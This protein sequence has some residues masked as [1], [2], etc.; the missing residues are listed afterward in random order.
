MECA[1][2]NPAEHVEACGVLVGILLRGVDHQPAV[3]VASNHVLVP[4]RLVGAAV[5]LVNLALQQMSGYFA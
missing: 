1:A 3:R 4:L 5:D 2:H